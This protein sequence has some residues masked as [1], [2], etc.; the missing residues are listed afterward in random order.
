M[1]TT[2]ALELDALPSSSAYPTFTQLLAMLLQHTRPTLFR[3]FQAL[4]GMMFGH[5]PVL[6]HA[7]RVHDCY[8]LVSALDHHM[9]SGPLAMHDGRCVPCMA[10]DVCPVTTPCMP[11]AL[12]ASAMLCV[13]MIPKAPFHG[14]PG[15]EGL[16]LSGDCKGKGSQH[17]CSL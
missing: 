5:H 12:D 14:L 6:V 4:V 8:G 11:G 16:M 3:H 13:N 17:L 10:A 2:S 15:L 7:K 1:S 9:T